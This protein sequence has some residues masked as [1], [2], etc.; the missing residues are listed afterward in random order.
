MKL[1]RPRTAGG[2]LIMF[3]KTHPRHHGIPVSPHHLQA[4]AHRSNRNI[5]SIEPMLQK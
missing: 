3:L 1:N 2:A 4:L 5:V